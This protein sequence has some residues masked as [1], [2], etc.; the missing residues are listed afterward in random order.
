MQTEDAR[1]EGAGNA[2][3]APAK[4]SVSITAVT[5][6]AI[7]A[8]LIFV[9]LIYIQPILVQPIWVQPIWVQLISV[10]P[11][12]IRRDEVHGKYRHSVSICFEIV[13]SG[14]RDLL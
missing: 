10:L 13:P 6:H 5:A 2:N 1:A 8:K 7:P 9:P 14:R 11:I 4:M 12:F 3:C